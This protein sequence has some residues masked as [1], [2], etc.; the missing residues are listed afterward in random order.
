MSCWVY[1]TYVMNCGNSSYAKSWAC[2]TMYCGNWA[3]EYSVTDGNLR[4]TNGNCL[5]CDGNLRYGYC[6][7]RYENCRYYRDYLNSMNSNCDENWDCASLGYGSWERNG[8][9]E[10]GTRVK[11]LKHTIYNIYR[12]GFPKK[13]K[14]KNYWRIN[15]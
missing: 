15:N 4:V 8:N 7:T 14:S 6:R 3:S 12:N 1:R 13:S 9:F 2:V 5:D 10:S 11:N